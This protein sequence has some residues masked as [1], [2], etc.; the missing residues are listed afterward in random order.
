MLPV[1]LG[2][3]AFCREN[4]VFSCFIL[5]GLF[6]FWPA[7]L[8]H[9]VGFVAALDVILFIGLLFIKSFQAIKAARAEAR[10]QRGL[11]R[12]KKKIV[13]QQEAER[14]RIARLPKP[15]PPPPP[16]RQPTNEEKLKYVHERYARN[17]RQIEAADLSPEDKE[18]LMFELQE[19]YRE[20]LKMFMR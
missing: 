12:E 5:C 13:Q 11:A 6:Y 3:Y 20:D 16:P 7:A 19:D 14:K 17:K 8:A 15:P 10:Y 18:A 9:F 2:I 1:T 4:P